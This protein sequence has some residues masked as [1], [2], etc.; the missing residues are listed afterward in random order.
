M[1]TKMITIAP[2]Q[3]SRLSDIGEVKPIDDDDADCLIEIRDVLKKHGKLDRFGVALLHSHFDIGEDEIML[4][5]NDERSRTLVT[6]PVKQSEDVN[7]NVG[8]IWVLTEGDI[9]AASRCYQRCKK[10][11]FAPHEREHRKAPMR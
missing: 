7:S 9:I 11:I 8:T 2:L 1:E 3:W 5:T 6:K 4:E 10:N